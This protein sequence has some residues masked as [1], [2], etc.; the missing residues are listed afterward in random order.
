MV[1]TPVKRR[2]LGDGLFFQKKKN[3]KLLNPSLATI[4]IESSAY[5]RKDGMGGPRQKGRTC[6]YWSQASGP[7]V[8]ATALSS[9]PRCGVHSKKKLSKR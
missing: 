5:H 8:E 1:K 2:L 9:V 3:R 6:I 4:E 7:V